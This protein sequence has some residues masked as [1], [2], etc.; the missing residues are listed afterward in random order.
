[1]QTQISGK[2]VA[3]VMVLILGLILAISYPGQHSAEQLANTP[4]IQQSRRSTTVQKSKKPAL[5]TTKRSLPQFPAK[6]EEEEGC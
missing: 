4:R 1:M 5:K 3:A 2:T 6:E